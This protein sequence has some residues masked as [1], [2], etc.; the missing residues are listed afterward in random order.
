MTRCFKCG[1]TLIEVCPNSIKEN[2]EKLEAIRKLAER[3][4]M[5]WIDSPEYY[6]LRIL[7]ILNS[8]SSIAKARK[9]E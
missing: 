7:R 9:E 3:D 8:Q 5:R 2:Q 6:K 4:R 1:A